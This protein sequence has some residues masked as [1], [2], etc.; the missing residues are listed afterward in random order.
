MNGHAVWALLPALASCSLALDFD[1]VGL[2]CRDD[3]D[4]PSPTSCGADETCRNA[5]TTS[6]DGGASS[7][8]PTEAEIVTTTPIGLASP[9]GLGG[10]P[11]DFVAADLAANDLRRVSSGETVCALPDTGVIGLAVVDADAYTIHPGGLYVTRTGSGCSSDRIGAAPGTSAF[12]A[13]AGVLLSLS[14][15]TIERRL[16]AGTTVSSLPAWT[17]EP[18][19]NAPEAIAV[20][21]GLIYVASTTSSGSR[22]SI[23]IE[24]YDARAT[25][26]VVR[27]GA[28]FDVAVDAPAVAGLAVD[29]D[30]MWILTAGSGDDAL[31]LVEARL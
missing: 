18:S 4:C 20:D 2:P 13:A 7:S 24:I 31:A 30:R 29:G 10:P 9:V 5:D 17:L 16:V 23:R 12:T 25:P 11:G 1:P 19:P 3:L 6:P 8:L 26:A 21:G 15:A 28:S 14:G 27:R 22:F